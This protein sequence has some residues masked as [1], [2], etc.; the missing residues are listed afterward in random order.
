MFFEVLCQDKKTR[1]GNYPVLQDTELGWI[2]SDKIPSPAAPEQAP[3]QSFF[4]RNNDNL[5]QQV[6][7]FWESEELPNNTWTAKEILCEEHFK[8][9][10][11]RDDRGRYTGR[12]P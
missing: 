12:L 3:R 8:K 2:I 6:Q 1:P 7:R 4:I 5:D 10:T 11:T 9:H